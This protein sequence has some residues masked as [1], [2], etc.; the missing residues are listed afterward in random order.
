MLSYI[1]TINKKTPHNCN[2]PKHKNFT[3]NTTSDRANFVQRGVSP[4]LQWRDLVTKGLKQALSYTDRRT[5]LIYFSLQHFPL[6]ENS[7]SITLILKGS[8]QEQD[9]GLFHTTP[10]MHL[11]RV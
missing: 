5:L 10:S 7:L 6:E 11:P 4:K 3:Y 8:S 2:V 1:I 9:C